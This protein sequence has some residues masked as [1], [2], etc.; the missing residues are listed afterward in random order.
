MTTR[1]VKI[2]CNDARLDAVAKELMR[3]AM[4]CVEAKGEFHIALSES[5]SLDDFYARL[6]CDPEMRAMPWGKMHVWCFGDTTNE[7]SIRLAIADHSGIPE[8]H[9][10]VGTIDS[11]IDCCLLSCADIE[12]IQQT[13]RIQCTAYLVIASSDSAMACSQD[14]VTHWFC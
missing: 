7:E 1:V 10:H 4:Q 3:Q 9:V 6:M 12:D 14:A 13:L 5:S 8:E 2:A 11:T